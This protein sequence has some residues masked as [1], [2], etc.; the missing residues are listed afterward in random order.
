LVFPSVII[1]P[2]K[3][4]TSHGRTSELKGILDVAG[5][6]ELPEAELLLST[7]RLH[8]AANPLELGN[9]WNAGDL[10]GIEAT[11]SA[12]RVRISSPRNT[13]HL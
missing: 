6:V 11:E 4:L 3:S 10:Q 13:K 7:C 12:T 1:C 2:T 5:D 9:S 8:L